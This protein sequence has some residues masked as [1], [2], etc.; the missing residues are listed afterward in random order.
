MLVWIEFLKIVVK[1]VVKE[2]LCKVVD[3]CVEWLIV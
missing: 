1:E 3:Y 2:F